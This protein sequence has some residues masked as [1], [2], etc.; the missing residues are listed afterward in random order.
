MSTGSKKPCM[1]GK[2]KPCMTEAGVQDCSKCGWDADEFAR[3]RALPLVRGEDGRRRKH[4]G[5]PPSGG[6]K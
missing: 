3:R 4:T 1:L 2:V 6:T 5:N